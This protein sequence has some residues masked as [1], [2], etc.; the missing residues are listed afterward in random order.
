MIL[1]NREKAAADSRSTVG[2]QKM[3]LSTFLIRYN[4]IIILVILIIAASGL[5]P[6]F[7]SK[8]NVFTLLRQQVPYLIIA[9]GMLMVIVTGGID[10][11]V[12]SV[13]AVSS[14][15]VA[16]SMTKWGLSGGGWSTWGAIVIGVGVGALFGALNGLLIARLRMPSFIVTLAM[17]YAG[18]G[19]AYIITKGN[20]LMLNN[21]TG[22]YADLVGFSTATTIFGIPVAVIFALVVVIIFFLVMKYTTF[23]RMVYAIGS[24][25]S[26]VQLA[27]INSKKHLFFVYLLSG[28]LCGIAGVIITARSGNSS[29]LTASV[30]YNMSTIAGVV[31]GGASLMGGEGTVVMTVIGVFIIAVIGNIMNLINLASYPQMV[32][33]AGVII[34]AVLLKSLS[35]KKHG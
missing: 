5:S 33:K 2:V 17:M 4:A 32:V 15:M 8:T 9:M 1:K 12:S 18:E 31:I 20:T 11:S 19:I 29:A 13:A 23:G 22:G 24:N 35:S 6:L 7:I 28:I 30:D 26:A 25:E 21:K 16:Y 27:G 3:S 10:L 14:I 34:L